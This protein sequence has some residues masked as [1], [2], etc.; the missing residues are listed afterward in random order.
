MQNPTTI[1]AKQAYQILRAHIDAN[2]SKRIY[3]KKADQGTSEY[4]VEING[5]IYKLRIY[6]IKHSATWYKWGY[7][8]SK[9]NNDFKAIEL[10]TTRES[11]KI[12]GGE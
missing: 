11:L 6:S 3:I 4:Y 9:L 8:F 7:S 1:P 5:E 10:L 12:L 2:K